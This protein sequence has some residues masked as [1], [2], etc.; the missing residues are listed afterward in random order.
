MIYWIALI[1]VNTMDRMARQRETGFPGQFPEEGGLSD[2]HKYQYIDYSHS[3]ERGEDIRENQL[4]I[5][6]TLTTQSIIS[7]INHI[8]ETRN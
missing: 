8:E 5:Q 3:G 1:I 7:K 6:D 4:A 2:W